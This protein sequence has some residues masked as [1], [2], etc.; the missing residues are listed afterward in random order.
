MKVPLNILFESLKTSVHLTKSDIV[1]L[2]SLFT[3]CEKL[4]YDN[5]KKNSPVKFYISYT[6]TPSVLKRISTD[7]VVDGVDMITI[8]PQLILGISEVLDSH[9]KTDRDII[10]KQISPLIFDPLKKKGFILTTSSNRYGILHYV[11][12]ILLNKKNQEIFKIYWEYHHEDSGGE[13]H[14]SI[15]CDNAEQ[16]AKELNIPS[17]MDNI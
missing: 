16:L 10:N 6:K 8:E 14:G 3:D 4:I 13:I 5:V 2:V 15:F 12:A 17:W 9:I 1:N 11:E 7:L